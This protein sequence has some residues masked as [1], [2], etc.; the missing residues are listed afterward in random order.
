M[1]LNRRLGFRRGSVYC[2]QTPVAG[3]GVRLANGSHVARNLGRHIDRVVQEHTEE[4]HRRQ[5]QGKP[6]PILI[7][8]MQTDQTSILIIEIEATLQIPTVRHPDKAAVA[9][10]LFVTQKLDRHPAN[11]ANRP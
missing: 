9:G 1:K 3:L 11:L 2:I 7:A 6:E 5:L 8:T 4:T 10:S